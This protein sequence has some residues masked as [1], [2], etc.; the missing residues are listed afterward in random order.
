MVPWKVAYCPSAGP[1]DSF[2][3]TAGRVARCL[4]VSMTLLPLMVSIPFKRGSA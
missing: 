2:M 1:R 4:F 3:L